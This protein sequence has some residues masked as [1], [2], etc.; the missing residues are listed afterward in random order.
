MSRKLAHTV[1]VLFHPLLMPTLGLMFMLYSGSYISLLP[2]EAKKLIVIVIAIN[3]FALPLLMIP[4]FYRFGIIKSLEMHEPR[5]RIIP[6]A[7]TLIPYLFS[8]YFLQKL[9]LPS[10]LSSF[11][12]GASV[13][14]LITLIIS[15]WWK[16]S[17]HLVGI[18]GLTG[19]I[20]AFSNRLYTDV[21][22]FIVIG[23][24]V[25]GIVAWARLTLNAH[26]PSQVY[27]GFGLGWG[28]MLLT[29][30]LI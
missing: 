20:F 10:L 8:F 7:F 2:Y 26:K 15:I 18:G 12:L 19:F 29:M 21:L 17:V 24:A 9:P 11:I 3:T 22:L 28:I 4:L 6:L 23:V 1:S 16:I 14:I 13:T 30:F 25:A 5:E 27:A